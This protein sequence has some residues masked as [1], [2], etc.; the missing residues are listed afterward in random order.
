MEKVFLTWDILS[1]FSFTFG[2]TLNKDIELTIFNQT[3]F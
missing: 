1:F 3:L 2:L